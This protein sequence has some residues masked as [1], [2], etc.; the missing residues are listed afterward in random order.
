MKLTTVAIAFISLLLAA[1]VQAAYPVDAETLKN[2][3]APQISATDV[4]TSTREANTPS[5]SCTEVNDAT[6]ALIK[7]FETFVSRP[8]LGRSRETTIG[9]GHRCQTRRCFE[10]GQL[11][12]TKD[13]A[14]ALL[15]RDVRQ[16]TK[17]I[18]RLLDH[19]VVL[20]DNQFGALVSW[21]FN[22]GCR[23][24][25]SSQLV[26]RL[27]SGESPNIVAT[28]ELP[29]WNTANGQVLPR[30]TKRRAAENDL[31]LTPSPKEAH[32]KCT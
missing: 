21:A 23:K 19:S 9:Y 12:L 15:K 6:I 1:P 20:N 18:S 3:K 10:V 29:K 2:Q 28:E 17:C 11:P 13:S 7:E 8:T 14:T 5:S 26:Q 4:N 25:R 22:I 31:S 16:F 30:L 27:N 24:V 32:P